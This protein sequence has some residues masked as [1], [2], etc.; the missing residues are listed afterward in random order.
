MSGGL[1]DKF[2]SGEWKN[3]VKLGMKMFVRGKLKIIPLRC[4]G[5]KEVRKIFNQAEEHR[6]R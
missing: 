6:K 2:K 5:V 1:K 4:E 3:D